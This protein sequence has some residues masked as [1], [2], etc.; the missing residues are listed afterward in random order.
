MVRK[1]LPLLVGM[2]MAC[3]N[4]AL[5]LYDEPRIVVV[6]DMLAD[7]IVWIATKKPGG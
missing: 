7:R 1:S 4:M 3:I 5:L 6:I 2:A